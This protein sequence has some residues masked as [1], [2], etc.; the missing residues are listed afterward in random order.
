[1]TLT[2]AWLSLR[3]RLIIIALWPGLHYNSKY[4]TLRWR[5]KILRHATHK[6]TCRLHIVPLR[7]HR[8]APAHRP[9]EQRNPALYKPDCGSPERRENPLR[10]WQ[11]ISQA[12]LFPYCAIL[13]PPHL[14]TQTLSPCNT[15]NRT[16]KVFFLCVSFLHWCKLIVEVSNSFSLWIFLFFFNF[17]RLL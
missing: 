13:T 17:Q 16:W 2:H 6:E 7:L 4:H 1:M 11:C 5:R 8:P 15:L 3:T 10:G 12:C 9:G 14:H